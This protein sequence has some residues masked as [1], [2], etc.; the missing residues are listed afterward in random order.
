MGI[1]DKNHRSFIIN[2]TT[3]LLLL[4]HLVHIL[5]YRFLAGFRPL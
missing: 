1:K 2:T 5:N 4:L 3:I